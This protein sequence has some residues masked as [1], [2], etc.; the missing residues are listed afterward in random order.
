[1]TGEEVRRIVLEALNAPGVID[2]LNGRRVPEEVTREAEAV[3]RTAGGA[4]DAYASAESGDDLI[5]RARTVWWA[6]IAL[7]LDADDRIRD[8]GMS[9]IPPE[10][11]CECLSYALDEPRSI[12]TNGVTRRRFSPRL[13]LRSLTGT[14]AG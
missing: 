6:S 1:M 8:L 5:T 7:G 10:S 3:L 12:L 4:V 14:L 9:E 11:F 13:L 2:V